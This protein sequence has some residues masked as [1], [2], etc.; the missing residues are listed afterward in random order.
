[1]IVN[2]NTIRFHVIACL[3]DLV[4]LWSCALQ[5]TDA[6]RTRNTPKLI[7]RTRTIGAF[8]IHCHVFQFQFVWYFFCIDILQVFFVVAE[9]N[10]GKNKAIL[11]F[12]L[13]KITNVFFLVF[14]RRIVHFP[15]GITTKFVC[16][17]KRCIIAC[18]VTNGMKFLQC[19][20]LGEFEKKNIFFQRFF[21][22][23]SKPPQ[24][25]H[26]RRK[27]WIGSLQ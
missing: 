7:P 13:F 8:T 4:L 1:M 21:P 3:V 2:G 14:A 18:H 22:K 12:A 27:K 15:K 16:R 19:H 24:K 6:T 11:V 9:C 25:Q 10:V 23:F 20:F 5:T 26:G 17:I